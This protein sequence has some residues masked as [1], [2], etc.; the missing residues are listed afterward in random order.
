MGERARE[1]CIGVERETE[2]ERKDHESVDMRKRNGDS[3]RL[4]EIKR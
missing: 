4:R 2:K 3:E 1:S